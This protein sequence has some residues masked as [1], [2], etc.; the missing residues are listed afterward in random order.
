MGYYSDGK[1]L[2]SAFKPND[3]ITLAEVATILSRM[4]RG[5]KHQGNEKWRYHNHLLTLQKAGIIPR[6]AN[7]MRKE[8]RGNVFEMMMKT[9][10]FSPTP[11]I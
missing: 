6:F 9:A 10:N 11:T 1:T 7:P 5:T 2:K 8:L 3:T 4:L